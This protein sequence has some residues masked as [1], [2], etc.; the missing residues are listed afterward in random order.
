M[1]VIL[2]TPTEIAGD[3]VVLT[4]ERARHIREVL[5]G[6]FGHEVRVGMIDGPFGT[7]TIEDIDPEHVALSC[8]FEDVMPELGE[9]TLLL[10]VPRPVVLRRCLA[11]AAALGFGWLVAR[12][13]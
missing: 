3:R 12:L 4:D 5:R 13:A 6:K 8:R 9:H 11:S 7:G 1:N 10:A 2:L